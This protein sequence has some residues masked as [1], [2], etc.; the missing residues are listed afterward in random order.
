MKDMF[1]EVNAAIYDL[2]W[3]QLSVKDQRL[4]LFA[5]QC[6]QVHIRFSCAGFHEPT[7]ERFLNV[8]KIA[9]NVVILTNLAK[10]LV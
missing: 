8:I 6:N 7:F 5:L 4:I 2:P 1:D 10:G 9:S 3:Y